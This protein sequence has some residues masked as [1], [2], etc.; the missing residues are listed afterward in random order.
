MKKSL[1]IFIA[2]TV[3]AA[4]FGLCRYE[5]KTNSKEIQKSIATKILRFHI[6]ANSDSETD[7]KLK[8]VVRDAIGD[9]LGE[10][11]EGVEDLAE[12][13]R[14]ISDNLSEIEKI[15]VKTMAEK[16]FDYG[17]KATLS[18]VEFPEKSYGSYTFPAGEYEALEVTLGA[19]EGHNWW[20][21]LYPNMCFSGSVYKVS[22]DA[23]EEL[24]EVL[25]EEEYDDVFQS[26]SVSIRF[27]LFEY[28]TQK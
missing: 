9:M 16:G 15:A 8:L 11:L 23:G 5:N 27:K 13:K 19:G 7:Q 14:I 4:I 22:D 26:D 1:I 28:F 21:V 24:K 17:A 2:L 3:F 10:K 18:R 6:L 20:C 25:S 12:S